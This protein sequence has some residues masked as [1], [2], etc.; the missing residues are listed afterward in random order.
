M[1]LTSFAGALSQGRIRGRA[2]GMLG[3]KAVIQKVLEI[4][5]NR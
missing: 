1:Y 4:W 3:N 5:V 2:V